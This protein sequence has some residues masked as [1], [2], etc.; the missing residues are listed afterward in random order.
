[1]RVAT[2]Y[3]RPS[4]PR[5]GAVA[6]RAAEPTAA[7]AD[8]YVAAV[9]HAQYVPT[10]TAVAML[11]HKRR[12]EKTGLVTLT[13]DLLSLKV[14]SES[15][16][17]LATSVSILVVLGLSVLDLGPMYATDARQTD[18][19][20]KHRLMHPPIRRGAIIMYE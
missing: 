11:C 5:L 9:S 18:I 17:T 12:S 6:P 13:F 20:Q 3:A 8:G 10:L 19:R 16:V 2:R 4:P 14:V 1:M 7:P 15:R